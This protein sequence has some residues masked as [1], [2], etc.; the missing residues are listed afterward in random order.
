MG[1]TTGVSSLPKPWTSSVR[2]LVLGI[3]FFL[4]SRVSS[5]R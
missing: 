3:F 5:T 2:P 1:A 4:A